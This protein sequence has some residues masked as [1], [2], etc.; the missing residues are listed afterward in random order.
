VVQVAQH[1]WTQVTVNQFNKRRQLKQRL[2]NLHLQQ[3]ALIMVPLQAVLTITMMIF[4]S[5]IHL[6]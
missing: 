3:L 5:R 1:L 6:R 4:R 2:L